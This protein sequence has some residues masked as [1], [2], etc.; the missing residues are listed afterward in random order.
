MDTLLLELDTAGAPR[1]G[2]RRAMPP[3]RPRCRARATWPALF[4]MSRRHVSTIRRSPPRRAMSPTA[5]CG[6]RPMGCGDI[7]VG[8]PAMRR[9][10]GRAP[11]RQFAGISRGV[12]RHAAGRRRRGAAARGA[13]AAAPAGD[14]RALPSRR[15][16]QPAPGHQ[17]RGTGVR[18]RDVCV[19][20]RPARGA[21]SPAAPAGQRPGHA[22]VHLR[23]H[24]HAQRGHAE[25]PQ[26]AGQCR[27]DPARSADQGG[28]PGAGDRPVLPRPGQLGAADAC[29]GGRHRCCWAAR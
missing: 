17:F 24:R 21:L 15:A 22:A 29:P 18:D 2:R 12:L 7:C 10:P 16:D 28:G 14:P 4:A 26:P 1:P 8:G 25:P 23:L 3:A 19:W 6:A 20:V 9:A 13:G 11:A 27:L 5:G